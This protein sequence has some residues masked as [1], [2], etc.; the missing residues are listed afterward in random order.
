M[1]QGTLFTK[2]RKELPA[3]EVSKNAL[4]L[5]KASFVNKEMAGVYSFL[6]LGLR[7]I[8][9]IEN[10]IREEMNGVGGQEILMSVFH[11]KEN[12]ERTGR[13]NSMDDL[14][15]VK[16]SS[17]REVAL[18]PTHEEIVVPLVQQFV[19]SYK[20]L[21]KAIYQIQDKFR[22]ELRAKS[23]LLR[24]REFVMKDMYSFHT[25]EED[26]GIFYNKMSETYKRIFDRVGIGSVTYLTFASGGSF[27]KYS[28]EFQAITPAGEDTI[29][30]DEKKGIA[31]NKEVYND[32][33]LT[34]LN[35]KKSDLVEKRA[36]E[37]GNIFELKTKYSTPFNMTYKDEQGKDQIVIMGCYGIGLGRLM[38]S[39]V[40]I[41]S[42]EKGMVWPESIAPYNVHI[43]PL[44]ADESVYEKAIELYD[45]LNKKG[46]EVLLDDRRDISAGGKFADSDLIGIPY[47]VV[48]SEK[49]LKA[50]G[51]EIK[52]RTE[53]DTQILDQEK[54][55]KLLIHA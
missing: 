30:V 29:Y 13:W 27:S 40:E 3:D 10:I 34:E 23:G 39:V 26:L 8:K 20:D 16:D 52:K 36:I 21:P 28:H 15:K 4:F 43:L 41:L 22:M 37:V 50:G 12:W 38:G 6:P 33:V 2:T 1:L 46:V 24:G 47:R 44:G 32:E 53:N 35:L 11:P 14:Y 42:D 7:V 49:S 25:N 51:Y 48:V 45:L 55:L 18:G 54:L 17:G 9:K 5:T 19:N 31:V